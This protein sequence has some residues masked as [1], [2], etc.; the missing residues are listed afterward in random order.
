[1]F[2]LIRGVTHRFLAMPAYDI[3][4]TI[5]LVLYAV[6]VEIRFGAKARAS[7]GGASDQGSTIALSLALA[8]PLIGF[9]FAMK[10]RIPISLPGMPAVAWIGVLLGALG[11]ILRLWSLLVLRDRFTRTLLIQ[12]GHRIERNGPY[13]FVRHPGYLGSLL[14]LN[15]IGLASGNNFTVVASVVVT[16]AAYRYRIRVED[17]M[18]VSE[19]G[20]SYEEYRR[21]VGA[22]FPRFGGKRS[23]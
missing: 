18:L 1:M 9:I 23:T 20:D 16:Y 2:D 5:I 21:S 14:C 8:V 13:R 7:R 19:F 10:G 3:A 17:A 15:G 22:L 6:Q 12:Q 4:A 11:F